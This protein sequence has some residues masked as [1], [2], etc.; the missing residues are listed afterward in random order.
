MKKEHVFI[1]SLVISIVVAI[2]ICSVFVGKNNV[3]N[4]QVIQSPSGSVRIQSDG[5]YYFKFLQRLG[6]I[7]KLTPYF[8]LMKNLNQKIKTELMLFSP[9]KER[10]IFPVK[11]FI[12]FILIM[13]VF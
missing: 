5:G 2:V 9:T 4:F 1:L 11:L 6:H 8:S 13:K 3:Q 12:V 10:V 7:L